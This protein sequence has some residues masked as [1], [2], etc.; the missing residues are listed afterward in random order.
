MTKT[1]KAQ[2]NMWFSWMR[3]QWIINEIVIAN[4]RYNLNNTAYRTKYAVLLLLNNVV[5]TE[6]IENFY[7]LYNYSNLIIH[8]KLLKYIFS[9]TKYNNH[10]D[11]L[12]DFPEARE[13]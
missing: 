6:S 11:K 12:V 8:L 13:I 10:W 1:Y 7:V 3:N 4:C 9:C 2:S 5:I